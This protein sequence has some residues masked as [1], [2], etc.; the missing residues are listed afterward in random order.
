MELREFY[1][2]CNRGKLLWRTYQ[3]APKEYAWL[4]FPT[5]TK[6]SNDHSILFEGGEYDSGTPVR[7]KFKE[8]RDCQR[9]DFNLDLH[10]IFVSFRFRKLSAK[11]I[12]ALQPRYTLHRNALGH[13]PPTQGHW[14]PRPVR[15]GAWHINRIANF[16][17][18][19]LSCIDTDRSESRLI[20]QHFSD[21]TKLPR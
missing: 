16:Q 12:W 6:L 10:Q 15:T 17:R 13:W 8:I 18:L 19:I 21:S 11:I 14:P 20:V 1:F 5:E 9:A 7:Q 2:S 3:K 4:D